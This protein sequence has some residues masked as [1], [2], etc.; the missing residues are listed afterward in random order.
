MNLL[1][2]SLQ[3]QIALCMAILFCCSILKAQSKLNQEVESTIGVISNGDFVEISGFASNKTPISQSIRFKFSVITTKMDTLRRFQNLKSEEA[4]KAIEQLER[5]IQSEEGR[6]VLEGQE[7]LNLGSFTLDSDTEDR[8]IVLVLIY[9]NDDK[10]IGQNRAVLSEGFGILADEIAKN[11]EVSVQPIVV[12]PKDAE[13]AQDLITMATIILA[14][15]KTKPGRDFYD[16]F[17]VT[18]RNKNIKTDRLITVKEV[19]ALGRNTKIEVLVDRD[20]VWQFFVRPKR[21]YLQQMVDISITR[22]SYKLQQLERNGSVLTQ[23]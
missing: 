4:I 22:I 2:F 19:L 7:K 21:Y 9:D 17:G 23:Y 8:V 1:K 11:E 10:L 6:K 18:F 13:D 12:N 15:T 16:I 14:D 5:V 20:L 3:K